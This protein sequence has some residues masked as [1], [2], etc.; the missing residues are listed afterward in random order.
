MIKM[1]IYTSIFQLELRQSR[2]IL[3]M[4]IA[5]RRSHDLRQNE[6][7][8]LSIYKF[9][10]IHLTKTMTWMTQWTVKSSNQTDFQRRV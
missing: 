5:A 1:E 9:G 4:T 10:F 6:S 8:V 7:Q 2:D 3:G